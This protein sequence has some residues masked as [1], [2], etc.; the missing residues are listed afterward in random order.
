MGELGM[1]L[2]EHTAEEARQQSA[3]QEPAQRARAGTEQRLVFARLS[4]SVRETFALE[5]TLAAG[6]IPAS[7]AERPIQDRRSAE[8]P[9]GEPPANERPGVGD[10]RRNP[11]S[12]Y[13]HDA[14]EEST[15]PKP[16]RAALHDQVEPLIEQH[17][18]DDPGHAY[19]GGEIAVMVCE[20]LGIPFKTARMQDELLVYP[21]MTVSESHR[22]HQ[23]RHAPGPVPPSSA[24]NRQ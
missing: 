16:T 1:Q 18:A 20:A 22:E 23:A 9:P 4:R 3:S 8:A 10:P 24:T 12:E 17:I 7:S 15:L 6:K 11:I 13:I 19:L 21:G 5:A 2:L 14:I